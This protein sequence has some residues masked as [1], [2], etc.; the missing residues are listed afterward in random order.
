MVAARRREIAPGAGG[1]GSYHSTLKWQCL[2]WPDWCESAKAKG[3]A[4]TNKNETLLGILVSKMDGSAYVKQSPALGRGYRS[5][6]F[7]SG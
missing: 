4:Y 1:G 5:L 2:A 6:S 3:I 7:C